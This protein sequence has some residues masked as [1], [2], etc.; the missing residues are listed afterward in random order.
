[1]ERKKG[2]WAGANPASSTA[3]EVR[4]SPVSPFRAGKPECRGA[5]HT[6]PELVCAGKRVAACQAIRAHR[7]ENAVDNKVLFVDDEIPIL[8]GYRRLLHREFPVTTAVGAEEGLAAIR[9]EGPFAVVISDMRM[10]GMT[11]AEFLAKVRE[12]SPATIRMLLTGYSDLDAA[13][14]AVN[15]GQIFRYL[16]KPCEKEILVE[17]IQSGLDIYRSAIAEKEIVKKAQLVARSTTEWDAADLAQ[18]ADVADSYI[19]P[20][21]GEAKACLESI[22]EGERRGYVV[23]L[24]LALRTLIEER[25]GE[26]PAIE[27][28]KYMAKML[29]KTMEPADRLFHWSRDV[30]M[31]VLNRHMTPMAV[32]L[33]IARL[34]LDNSQYI[35]EVEDRKTMIVNSVSFDLLPISRFAAVEELFE[36]FDAKLVG[37]L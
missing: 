28:L 13:I 16:T 2:G 24:K 31:M 23:L 18:E 19:L 6:V 30:L 9:T 21:P 26:E 25:Y 1:M 11:G 34:N 5:N 36:A 8:E 14:S 33:Q 15:Q 22:F 37:K 10:P 35:L 20:G 3:V 27:Y 32:R 12:K 17:A 4:T 29:M 7:R